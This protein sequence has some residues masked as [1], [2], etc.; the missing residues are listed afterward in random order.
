MSR[1]GFNRSLHVCRRCLG[2]V[3]EGD[4]HFVCSV[5]DA[6]T[7]GPVANICGC[8]IRTAGT[9]RDL[10]FKYAPNPNRS[11]QSP[12]AVVILFGKTEKISAEIEIVD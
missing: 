4:N 2:P 5:C 9:R 6:D 7:D 10:G 11:A 1:F 3:L 12:A 8:G